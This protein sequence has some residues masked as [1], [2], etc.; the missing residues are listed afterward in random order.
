MHL[1]LI[2]SGILITLFLFIL[3][4]ILRGFQDKSEPHLDYIVV[5]G[6]QMRGMI[7]SRTLQNRLDKAYAYLMKNQG[8]MV[9]VSGGQGHD[10][11]ITEAEGM[12]QYLCKRG[13]A[14]VRIRKEDTSTNTHRNL[15][16]SRALIEPEAF[17][18]IVSS[19]YHIFRALCLAQKAGYRQVYGI[20]APSE[21]LLLIK[22]ITRE[23]LAV[24]KD[25]LMGHL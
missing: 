24:I 17:V 13:I 6:A 18:G 20:P 7:P 14:P 15:I 9:I 23:I 3:V 5:L 22:N 12:Y 11:L 1:I 21:P 10:E 25:G 19:D 8:T 4:L 2:I 16:N